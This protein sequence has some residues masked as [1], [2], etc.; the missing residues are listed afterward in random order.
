MK[1]L[2]ATLFALALPLTFATSALAE[3]P[4]TVGV[5]QLD[6]GFR[7]GMG[8]EDEGPNPF[9]MGLGVGLGYTLQSSVYVGGVFDY[10]FGETVTEDDL[11]VELETSANLWQAMGEV[12]YDLGLSESWVLRGKGGLG[13]ASLSAETCPE[14]VPCEDNSRGGLAFAPGVGLMYLGESFS[15]GVEGRYDVVFTEDT[16]TALILAVGIGF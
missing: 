7:Y 15:F 3:I 1:T 9:G 12:G 6:V 16:P 11:G 5:L 10:F 13:Y 4:A 2:A 14:D 8:F